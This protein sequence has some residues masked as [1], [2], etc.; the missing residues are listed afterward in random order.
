MHSLVGRS[1]SKGLY[2]QEISGK[3]YVLS[4]VRKFLEILLSLEESQEKIRKFYHP[5]K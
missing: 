3:N 5:S 2:G 4:T 1:I